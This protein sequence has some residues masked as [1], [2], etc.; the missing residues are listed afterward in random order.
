MLLPNAE[1]FAFVSRQAALLGS[2]YRGES[3][4][5]YCPEEMDMQAMSMLKSLES[6]RYSLL[7]SG[8]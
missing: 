5:I 8:V 4:K 1:S 6:A 7:L 2:C 3:P